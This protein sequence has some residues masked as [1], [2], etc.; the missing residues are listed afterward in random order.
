MTMLCHAMIAASSWFDRKLIAGRLLSATATVGILLFA[1]VVV[2]AQVLYGSITGTVTDP[3]GAVVPHAAIKITQVQTG[4]ARQALS[5]SSGGYSLD[6]IPEG[7]YNVVISTPG[8]KSF[9]APS[10]EVRLNSVV[11]VNAQLAVGEQ[12]QR[13]E[14]N[15]TGAQLQTDSGKVQAD[16][17]AAEL[18][19][20]P[21]PTR[22]YAGLLGATAGVEPPGCCGGGTNNP[23]KTLVLAANGTS[24]SA[25]DVRIEGVSAVNPWVQY[26]S[27][28]A[29]SVDSVETVNMVTGASEADQTLAGGATINVQLKSG[30]NAIHGSVYEY[31]MDNVLK[32]KPY[33][34]P[35]NT[36]KSKFI[37]NDLGGTVGGPIIKNKLFYFA[38]YEG[39]F[40]RQ[41]GGSFGTVP[42]AAIR[43]G[44]F[45]QITTPIYDPLTGN[46]DGTGK[47]QFQNNQIPITRFNP[48]SRQ[49]LAMVPLPNTNVFGSTYNNNYFKST[50]SG[51]NL[52]SYSG[53]VDWDLTSSIRITGRANYQPYSNTQTPLFGSVLGDGGTTPTQRGNIFAT[54]IAATYIAR[55]N[56]VLDGTFGF[57]RANQL[58][59]PI[60][61]NV[62]Y[63]SEV[64]KI[65]GVNL[66]PLPAGG[67]LPDFNINGFTGYGYGYPYLQYLDPVFQYAAN[68]TWSKGAHALRFGGNVSQQH[69]NHIENSQD[70]FN[71]SGG[72]TAL[73]GGISPN[74]Y[75][76]YADFLLGEV[77]SVSNSKL[78]EGVV[79]LRTWQ[80]ALYASDKW[81][82]SKKLTLTYGTAW[83]YFPVP[84]HGNYGLENYLPSTNQYEVCGYG[85]IP[86]DCGI[87]VSKGLFA[88]KIG[89]AYRP[90]ENTV[91]PQDMG[92]LRTDKHGP[93]RTE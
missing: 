60:D 65:P 62:K 27:T 78:N 69:M 39:D 18:Q 45:S 42:T 87:K 5:N 92:S 64:L 73:N 33:F 86:K 59:I 74:Q 4:E 89:F 25:T 93:R 81:N 76:G 15:A 90:I 6:N 26:H 29:P 44:D 82:V 41:G 47:T 80:F 36:R 51:Y 31:H 11:R 50:P 20:L 2:N 24:E 32:A 1:P 56:L 88:P 55:P 53:K 52:Q 72:S 67:G 9:A 75:N 37:D 35:P 10:I 30:T 71:F 83:E 84:T 34:Y 12:A 77:Q 70:G 63:G 14:V 58:L 54:T 43:A 61:A 13:V 85:G 17:T 19:S 22:N 68:G 49:L 28:L 79:R 46:S 48:I 7:T 38:A 91:I 23:A 57:T 40:T 21:Q 3:S 8:F 16:I 66:S